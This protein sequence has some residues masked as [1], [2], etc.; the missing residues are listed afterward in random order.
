MAKITE[1]NIRYRIMWS[2][3]SIWRD[4]DYLFD[5]K[6]IGGSGSSRIFTLWPTWVL[7]EIKMRYYAF[8]WSR[9]TMK[10]NRNEWAE[11]LLSVKPSPLRWRI[12]QWITHRVYCF[13]QWRRG[14]H[15]TPF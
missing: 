13:K 11:V 10:P 3:F 4:W 15:K 12:R 9:R 2:R 6:R 5:G 7:W 14:V 8:D 1:T